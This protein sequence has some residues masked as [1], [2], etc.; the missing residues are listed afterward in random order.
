[1]S[2]A[3][4]GHV[5]RLLLLNS[6]DAVGV[7][8]VA[9]YIQEAWP[10]VVFDVE[11][12][13]GVIERGMPTAY[14]DARHAEALSAAMRHAAV[15]VGATLAHHFGPLVVVPATLGRRQDVAEIERGLE[16]RQVRFAH[17][18]VDVPTRVLGADPA[19][20]ATAELLALHTANA[21]LDVT[22]CDEAGVAA[23]LVGVLLAMG[24]LRQGYWAPPTPPQG[25]PRG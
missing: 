10:A 19:L 20:V 15:Q 3:A 2:V 16:D 24:W 25:W 13:A 1:M 4:P 17:V 23:D 14:H 7:R 22:G 11:A 9:R 8:S 12:Q 21:R 6:V 5:P 18:V